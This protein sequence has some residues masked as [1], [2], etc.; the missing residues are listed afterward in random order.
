MPMRMQ[1]KLLRVLQSGEI[2]PV[3]SDRSHLVDV[4]VLAATH[5]DL[6]ALVGE[7]RFRED[8]YFRLNV[9]PVFV[10]P[11]RERPG[12][13]PA[14]AEYLLSQARL[15]ASSTPVR[16]ISEHALQRLAQASWPGNVR[17][18]ASAIERAVVFSG[19]EVPAPEHF[20]PI[21]STVTSQTPVWPA[22]DCAPWRLE[23]LTA[24]YTDWVLRETAGDK[25]RAAR[26]LDID[27]STL[28]R[29]RRAHR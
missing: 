10:P 5:R 16:S 1:A 7:G 2:R 27:V 19:D 6:P 12:D 3:G 8:L 17:E 20:P 24:A 18:L 9:L 28:Y 26:I 14:L 23:R 21:S 4:R 11:L 22:L 29:W 15:R 25:P 13:I